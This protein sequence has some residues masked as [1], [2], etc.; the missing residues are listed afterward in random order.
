MNPMTN[1]HTAAASPAELVI[2]R[3]GGVCALARLLVKN[4]STIS[5]WKKPREEGGTGGLVPSQSQPLL[6]ALAQE[7]GIRLTPSELL[8]GVPDPTV[9][10]SA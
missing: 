7:K 4:P 3:F 5:R 6:L 1:T 8:T 10:Q 9:A 2:E